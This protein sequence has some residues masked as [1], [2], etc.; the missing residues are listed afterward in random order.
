M[1]MSPVQGSGKLQVPKSQNTFFCTF[2]LMEK[3]QPRLSRAPLAKI[4]AFLFVL[5]A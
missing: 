2:P 1:P 3:Y 4:K 5:F